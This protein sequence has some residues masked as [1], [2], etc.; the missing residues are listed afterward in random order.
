M[1]KLH[2]RD[3]YSWCVYSERLDIDFNG[4]AWI[5]EGGNVLVDPVALTPHDVD[6][7]RQ[8]GG[9]AWIVVTNSDHV[10]ASLAA[11]ELFGAKV[12]G[13]AKEKDG[14]PIP[15]DRWLGEGDALVPGLVALELE[16][17]KTP[18]ELALLLEETTLLAGD[19]VRSHRAGTLMMLNDEQK[20]A[21]RAKAVRSIERLAALPKVQAVLV[22][23][24]VLALKG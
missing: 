7:L 16:G 5:R 22:G 12:A 13:P 14:F 11:K 24:L 10:R 15:C 21:D 9:A 20:L 6:H 17:S 19:L 23:D 8:L 4:F 3:L 1:K 2:R 18:G